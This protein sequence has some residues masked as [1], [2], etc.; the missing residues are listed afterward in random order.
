MRL[1][2]VRHPP[3]P[4][5]ALSWRDLYSGGA[6]GQRELVEADRFR[7]AAEERGLQLGMGSETLEHL[8]LIGAFSPVAFSAGYWS[9]FDVPAVPPDDVRFREEQGPEEWKEY[10]WEQQGFETVTALFS[11]WQLLYVDDVIRGTGVELGVELLVS[12]SSAREAQLEQVRG[13]L[14]AQRNALQTLDEAWG[15]AIK[16]LVALQNRYL[17]GLTGRESILGVPEGWIFAGREWALQTAE[18]LLERTASSAEDVRTLYEFFVERGL[19]RDPNDGLTMLRRARPRAFHKRWR[20]EARRAQDNFDAAELL[21]S[22]L[23][24]LRKGPARPESWP[25]DG[26]QLERFALYDRGP[27]AGWGRE[28]LKRQLQDAEL[29]PAGVHLVGEGVSEEIVVQRLAE[30]LLDGQAAN[31]LEFFD[32]GGTGSAKRIGPLLRSFADYARRAVVIVDNEGEMARYLRTAVAKGEIDQADVLLFDDSLEGQNATPGELIALAKQIAENPS[33][34][35]E[36]VSFELTEDELQA[37]HADRRERSSRNGKPG[38]ADSLITLVGQKTE[39]RLHLDKLELA[40]ALA[41]MLVDEFIEA[42]EQRETVLERRPVVR[43]FVERIAPELN[44]PIPVGG[45]I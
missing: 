24:E 6:F 4:A 16:L 2:A 9:G 21:R 43:F 13:L 29:F 19:A 41:A 27:A 36:P 17:P 25:M 12:D 26:R 34:N 45:E 28:E 39:G 32:L 1:F 23:A 35:R 3:I 44:R 15:P 37:D 11:P 14:E 30:G 33:A 42:G 7:S 20:G 18:T 40:E 5:L 31:E 8:D 10:S 22:F 38:I